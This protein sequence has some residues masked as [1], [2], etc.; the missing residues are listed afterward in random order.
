[1]REVDRVAMGEFGLLLIQMM[2][3]AGL[4]LAELAIRRFRPR[5]VAVLW[6]AQGNGGGG[7][8]AA[9][10]PRQT[11]TPPSRDLQLPHEDVHRCLPD[12][13]SGHSPQAK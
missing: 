4:H 12:N 8:V 11:P 9:R 6:V 1:M 13:V 5:A 7:L 2:E 3:N 10:H